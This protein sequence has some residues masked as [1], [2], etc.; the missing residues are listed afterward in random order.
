M[1]LNQ[2][3][4]HNRV[5]SAE[6]LWMVVEN[7]TRVV[8]DRLCHEKGIDSEADDAKH[9]LASAIGF[10]P[11]KLDEGRSA[12]VQALIE[13]GK[14]DPRSFKRDNSHLDALDA[15]IRREVLLGGDKTCYKQLREMSDGFEHGY[16]TFGDVRRRSEVADAAFT[17]L[18]RAILREIGLGDS[19][20]MF[21]ERFGSPQAPGG[22]SSRAT[23]STP[24]ALAAR[25]TSA[26]RHS[27]TR[28]PTLPDCHSSRS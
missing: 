19:S 20:P 1:A 4:P 21:D 11:K 8:F 27:M 12:E 7:M 25:S 23:G 28:G 17:H 2:L 18:R 9:S 3:D 10:V 24:T 14:L 5:L 6:S 16:M 15:Y 22:R 26:Q 13:A